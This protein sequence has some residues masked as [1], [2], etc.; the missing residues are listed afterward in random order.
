M[1]RVGGTGRAKP[2]L[3]TDGVHGQSPGVLGAVRALAA[4]GRTVYVT[5]SHPLSA[6]RFS[7][8]SSRRIR[9]PLATGSGYAPAVAALAR[10]GDYAAVL[11]TSDAAMRALQWPGSRFLDR[12]WASRRARH[13]G[14]AVPDDLVFDSGDALVAAGATLSYPVVVKSLGT[15][16]A[17]RADV[18]LTDPLPTLAR[19]GYMLGARARRA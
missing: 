2:V 5:V 6:A 8:H 14:L 19:V 4:A 12:A 11:P 3:V 15:D 18:S 16:G 10:S 7:R 9:V 13:V 17:V 1:T